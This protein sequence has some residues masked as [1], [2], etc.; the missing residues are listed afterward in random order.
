[1]GD[2]NAIDRAKRL[3]KRI[4]ELRKIRAER[5]DFRDSFPDAYIGLKKDYPEIDNEKQ[6]SIL[7]PN[8][9]G[10]ETIVFRYL[11]G[12]SADI[13]RRI[14]ELYPIP[15]IDGDENISLDG[16]GIYKIEDVVNDELTYS[17]KDVVEIVKFIFDNV[18]CM[19]RKKHG[20]IVKVHNFN[21]LLVTL[22][23][24]FGLP[25]HKLRVKNNE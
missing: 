11:K 13:V 24:K 17:S 18:Y 23:R 6:I 2:I 8:F 1:M 15:E 5:N 14:S 25:I 19:E 10:S 3:V 16:Y 12:T 9:D 4:A 21:D 7:V 20:Y 22:R